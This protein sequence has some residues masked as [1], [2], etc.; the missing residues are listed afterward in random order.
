MSVSS[1]VNLFILSYFYKHVFR[2]QTADY[3]GCLDV[4]NTTNTTTAATNIYYKLIMIEK[5]YIKNYLI[6]KECEI[7]FSGGLN[8]LTGETGAGKSILIDA[9]SL[10]LGERADYSII[11]K[12][13]DK[14]IV[15]GHFN[16]KNNKI[17]KRVLSEI[18]PDEEINQESIILRRELLN[19]G[20]SRNF[21]C[22]SPVNISDMKK[23]GD[24]LIDV[25]SQNEHQ[26]LLEKEKHIEILD[27][28]LSD[29]DLFSRYR[30]KFSQ[31]KELVK[32]FED[33]SSK[34]EE[35]V[36][37]KNFLEFELRELNNLNIQLNEDIDIEDELNKL[38]NTEGILIALNE[39]L[40]VL[41]EDKSNAQISVSKAIKEINKILKYDNSLSKLSEDLENSHILIKES[42]EFLS[43]YRNELNLDTEK[44]EQLR[45]RLSN[46]N[47]LKKKY[48]LSNNELIDRAKDIQRELSLVDN[49]DYETEKLSKE[50]DTERENL[51]R[52]GTEI[53]ELR[54]LESKELEKKINKLFKEVGLE[55]AEFKI[56]IKNITGEKNDIFSSE[57]DHYL[58]S[59]RGFNY[60]E[61]FIKTNKGS[62]FLPLKK[63]VS[64]G[65]VSRI[66]LSIKTAFAEKD[67]IPIL[68]FDEID[69]GISGRI[70][71]KVGKTLRTLS[72]THQ[73][74]CITHLPQIA[75]ASERHFHVS[76]IDT[77]K[78]TTASFKQLTE[79]EKITEV[80]K[81]ISG[82]K[83]TEAS[84]KSAMEL[85]NY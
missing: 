43:S 62:E 44:I 61:F 37:K 52:I 51:F 73:I 2:S 82:E 53:S 29:K 36:S 76:K 34:K 33:T 10:I 47:H 84:K 21:I 3:I 26:S 63:S 54:K 59:S 6:I 60:V 8:I 9:L 11:K 41:Y 39:A 48:N 55:T 50:I 19:K 27:N 58:L 67:E 80:A 18:L 42:S 66:M 45:N 25:H 79:N 38:E 40:Q 12:G 1:I 64:G 32:F 7:N 4:T 56:E 23:F 81:L 68:I 17:I 83:I 14:L 75:A 5:L 13:Q 78:E 15:E 35:I 30:V 16:F 28:Y 74:I 85:I 57:K 72:E 24:V 22:D 71:Q 20:V 31:F 49:F 70:A 77:G 65:E 69:S 46:I